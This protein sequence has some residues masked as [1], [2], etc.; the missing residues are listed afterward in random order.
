MKRIM[1]VGAGMTGA[2]AA[3]VL[4]EAGYIVDVVDQKAH[5]GGA[6]HDT[7]DSS[8]VYIHQYGPHI[9]HTND[10]EVFA[11]VSRFGNWL[12]YE[13]RVLGNLGGLFIPIPFNFRSIDLC[14][15]AQEAMAYKQALTE[16]AGEGNTITIGALKAQQSPILTRLAEFIYENIFL[17]YTQK[18]W[19]MSPGA[20]VGDVMHRVP[21]R[22]SYEDRYFTDQ[23]QMLP[24][25]GYTRF[26]SKMLDHP[27]IR[28]TLN[29]SVPLK[30]RQG[31]LRFLGKMLDHP[32]LYTGCVA[33]LFDYQYGPLPYRTLH[34]E[35][36]KTP[37]PYQ[38]AAVVNYPDALSRQTRITEFAHFYLA[39]P[40]LSL[41]MYEYPEAYD[42]AGKSDPFY[43]VPTAE[44]HR[45][46]AQ[47][48]SDAEAVP[49]LYFAGRLGNYRYINMDVAVRE[50]MEVARKIQLAF[51]L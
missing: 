38:P 32:I 51:P 8:G 17:H 37:W 36:K 7:L 9:F 4:A 42:P 6:A 28:C 48:R 30:M 5:V 19:G 45:L 26:V 29:C 47:Y 2:S 25:H 49:Y 20:L 3:R 12:P 16:A 50:G 46:F 18:Q 43:P 15:S 1:V 23:H 10:A 34:F 22:A 39:N 11:Y 13:H 41:V 33:A 31:E 27:N 44:N 14:F 35:T 24:T 40:E 21:V